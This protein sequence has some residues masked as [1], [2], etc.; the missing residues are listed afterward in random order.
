MSWC[1]NELNCSAFARIRS[2]ASSVSRSFSPRSSAAYKQSIHDS[3]IEH[4]PFLNSVKKSLQT[5]KAKKIFFNQCHCCCGMGDG[6]S[7]QSPHCQ[8]WGFLQ[9][10]TC[11]RRA[12]QNR[13][14][15][16]QWNVR[17]SL[18]LV[19]FTRLFLK[20]D[21]MHILCIHLSLVTHLCCRIFQLTESLATLL[22]RLKAG[23]M[24][25]NLERKGS[26]AQLWGYSLPNFYLKK[27]IFQPIIFLDFPF[28]VLESLKNPAR[29][30]AQ[31]TLVNIAPFLYIFNLIHN[32]LVFMIMS[33][34]KVRYS[35]S[36]IL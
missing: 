21:F 18:E 17:M 25:T 34:D 19:P 13:G 14:P 10:S 29:S 3:I 33:H 16:W 36:I 7:Y 1:V 4:L 11:G 28:I 31:L 12:G 9:E 8:R 23:K 32:F 2:V 20:H 15:C 26:G 35:T 27:F 30:E 6:H 22:S 24:V 5:K